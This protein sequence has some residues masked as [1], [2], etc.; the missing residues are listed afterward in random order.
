[1][2]LTCADGLSASPWMIRGWD[3]PLAQM[4]AEGPSPPTAP[5]L[6]SLTRILDDF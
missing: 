6:L 1:M 4:P 3:R 5:L 2:I